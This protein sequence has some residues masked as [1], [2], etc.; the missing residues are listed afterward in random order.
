MDRTQYKRLVYTDSVGKEVDAVI[1]GKLRWRDGE[2]YGTPAQTYIISE[3]Y[4]EP[5]EQWYV[6]RCKTIHISIRASRVR[7]ME[8]ERVISNE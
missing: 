8:G 1:G 7:H 6:I 5:D 2:T 4:R 3:I